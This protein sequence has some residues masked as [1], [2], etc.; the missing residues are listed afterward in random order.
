MGNVILENAKILRMDS[1]PDSKSVIVITVMK[2]M[3][4]TNNYLAIFVIIT[5]SII[6]LMIEVTLSTQLWCH[7]IRIFLKTQVTYSGRTLIVATV[8]DIS[9]LT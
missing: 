8:T 5:P 1:Y 7:K 4:S 9:H 3:T 6:S 2:V